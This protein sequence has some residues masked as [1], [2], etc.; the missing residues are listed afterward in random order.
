MMQTP[1]F[2]NGDD[3]TEGWRHDRPGMRRVFRQREMRTR[4][5]I[6]RQVSPQDVSQSGFIHADHAIK[7]YLSDLRYRA[8]P[9]FWIS[10]AFRARG[11]TET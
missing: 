4:L 7:A 6:V 5:M 3:R 9:S 8:M 1:D 10:P 11:N 2:W